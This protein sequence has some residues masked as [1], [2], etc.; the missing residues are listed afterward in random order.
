MLHY[1]Q[2]ATNKGIPIIAAAGN[3]VGKHAPDPLC[4]PKENTNNRLQFTAGSVAHL[5]Y[6]ACF[7]EKLDNLIAINQLQR[8][9]APTAQ[10][11]PCFYQNY[12]EHYVNAGVLNNNQ[13]CG[14]SIMGNE[15]EGSSFA[16]PVVTGILMSATR[17]QRPVSMRA[18][19]DKISSKY[20][21]KFFT[22]KGNYFKY[23]FNFTIQ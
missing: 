8:I 18:F 4:D 22:S 7:S 15:I 9:S 2:T 12:S 13:C 3:T 14:F 19:V 11:L 1:V 6:P 5:F 17:D 16:T 21:G 10:L 20:T 23:T